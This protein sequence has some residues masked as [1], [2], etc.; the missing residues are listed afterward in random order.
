MA[1]GHGAQVESGSLRDLSYGEF[2]GLVTRSGGDMKSIHSFISSGGKAVILIDEC[3]A[4]TLQEEFGVTCAAMPR[5]SKF[6]TRLEGNMATVFDGEEFLP[7]WEGLTVT[8]RGH[9]RFRSQLLAGQSGFTCVSAN[10]PIGGIHCT[11]LYGPIG[12]G[13]VV[14][15]ITPFDTSLS[16]HYGRGCPPGSFFQDEHIL[17]R[18]NMEAGLR[19]LRWLVEGEG[20]LDGQTSRR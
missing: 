12:R 15:M 1:F 11:A 6:L 2:G 16:C 13:H 5:Y 9:Y 7:I 14:F 18:D 8:A 3:N 20:D 4:E 19:L 17:L 10:D